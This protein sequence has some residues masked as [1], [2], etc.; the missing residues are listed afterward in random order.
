MSIFIFSLA[1]KL[2]KLSTYLLD[3]FE[4]LDWAELLHF[5]FELA[6]LDNIK[7]DDVIETTEK[8]VDLRNHHGYNLGLFLISVHLQ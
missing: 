6:L 3:E 8:K 4:S 2:G 1:I 7:V 5:A